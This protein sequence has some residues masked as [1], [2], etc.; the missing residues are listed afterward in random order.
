MKLLF[1][2]RAGFERIIKRVLDAKLTAEEIYEI[3][4]IGEF[5]FVRN[6]PDFTEEQR[7]LILM[8][9]EREHREIGFNKFMENLPKELDFLNE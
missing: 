5:N 2:R 4:E 6:R 8:N 7:E 3:K 9:S 1:I